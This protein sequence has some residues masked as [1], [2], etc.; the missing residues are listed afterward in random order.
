MR[1]FEII[2]ENEEDQLMSD[3]NDLL[4]AAKASGIDEIDTEEFAQQLSDLGHAVTP[5]SLLSLFDKDR[6]EI[7]KNITANVLSLSLQDSGDA[8]EDYEEHEINV[9]RD[10]NKRAL[11]NI[12]DR[13]KQ[14]KKIAKG[15]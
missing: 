11:S 7:I 1:F 9:E 14:T 8:E 2:T 10:A 13:A 3:I 12:K 15:L 5:N 4:V 6:P